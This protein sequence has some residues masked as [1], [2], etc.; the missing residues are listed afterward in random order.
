MYFQ[1]RNKNIIKKRN[2]APVGENY[3]THKK[4]LSENISFHSYTFTDG[5]AGWDKHDLRDPYQVHL[6]SGWWITNEQKAESEMVSEGGFE[7]LG[8]RESRVTNFVVVEYY[9][10]TTEN[11]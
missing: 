2:N 4:M 1:R 11:L 3:T 6:L 5:L 9:Q 10:R 7:M 8:E